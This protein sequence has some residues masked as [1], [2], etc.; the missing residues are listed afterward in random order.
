M[1]HPKLVYVVT[2]QMTHFKGVMILPSL[3]QTDGCHKGKTKKSDENT[4][5]K[6]FSSLFSVIL[7]SCRSAYNEGKIAHEGKMEMK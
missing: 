7:P 5:M 4:F 6:A 1:F 3:R 2:S